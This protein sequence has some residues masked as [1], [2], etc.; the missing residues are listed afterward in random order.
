M[1]D[2]VFSEG[3]GSARM[4]AFLIMSHDMLLCVCV[5]LVHKQGVIICY[6]L[7][8]FCKNAVSVYGIFFFFTGLTG[9]LSIV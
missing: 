5:H 3:C 4:H 8:S 9:K 1:G 6:V 7:L 2:R